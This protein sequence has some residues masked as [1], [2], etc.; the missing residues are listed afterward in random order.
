MTPDPYRHFVVAL[1]EAVESAHM[2]LPDFRVCK[3][4]FAKLDATNENRDVVKFTLD[5][6]AL[7]V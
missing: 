1:P 3:K 2:G 6:Q 5:Q 4:I 7:Y